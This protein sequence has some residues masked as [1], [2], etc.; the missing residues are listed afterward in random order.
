[1]NNKIIAAIAATLLT[2]PA[3]GANIVLN[4]VDP[5]GVG[6][7]DPTPAAPVPVRRFDV[8]SEFAMG[9]PYQAVYAPS[10]ETWYLM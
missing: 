1:M 4:N 5:A 10:S 3:F 8:T 7:N 9:S 6:F 2:A